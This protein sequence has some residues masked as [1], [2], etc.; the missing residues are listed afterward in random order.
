MVVLSG[1]GGMEGL[2]RLARHSEGSTHSV[3][4]V[5]GNRAGGV[6]FIFEIETPGIHSAGLPG[7]RI[8]GR[9]RGRAM[10]GRNAFAKAEE[11][12]PANLPGDY[13]GRVWGRRLRSG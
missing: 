7:G 13:P 1:C 2:Q 3:F 5:V 4:M 6:L 8:A 11:F 9:K 12:M 10:V